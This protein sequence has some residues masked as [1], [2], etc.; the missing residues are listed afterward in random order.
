MQYC[1][2]VTLEVKS[3]SV[4]TDLFIERYALKT[5][6]PVLSQSVPTYDTWYS[7]RIKD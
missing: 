3:G 7:T 1:K 2:Q 5:G 4:V 6:D